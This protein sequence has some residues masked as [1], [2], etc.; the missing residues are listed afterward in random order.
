MQK[1]EYAGAGFG[2]RGGK[3]GAKAI[4]DT[5]DR[6]VLTCRRMEKRR[7]FFIG[8]KDRDEGTISGDGDIRQVIGEMQYP[9]LPR[10]DVSR[11]RT[12]LKEPDGCEMER[13]SPCSLAYKI[14]VQLGHSVFLGQKCIVDCLVIRL[15]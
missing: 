14:T 9:V 6:R 5:A 4:R 11:W 12:S 8:L 13:T 2:L 1:G 3:R 15:E 10:N 7:K